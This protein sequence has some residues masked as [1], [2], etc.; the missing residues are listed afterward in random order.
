M[1]HTKQ[2]RMDTDLTISSLHISAVTY[3]KSYNT[4][5]NKIDHRVRTRHPYPSQCT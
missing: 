3:I 1:R 2:E 5:Q 4:N